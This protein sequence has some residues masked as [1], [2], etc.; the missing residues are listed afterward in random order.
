MSRCLI[1]AALCLCAVACGQKT[2]PVVQPPRVEIVTVKEPVPVRVT[3][4]PELL[5]PLKMP[6]P[7][8][9]SPFDPRATSALDAE[10]ERLLRGM[11]EELRQA[12]EAWIAWWMSLLFAKE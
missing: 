6:L 3:P 2:Q 4:P 8:F 12:R 9:I 1:A 5:A 7:V 10:G 11:L